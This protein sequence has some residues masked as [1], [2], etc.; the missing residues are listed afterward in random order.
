VSFRLGLILSLVFGLVTFVVLDV[1]LADFW[2]RSAEASYGVTLGIT[3]WRAYQ[4]R[5]LGPYAVLLISGLGLSYV[6]ALKV[7]T[8]IVVV[9]NAGLFYALANRVT[10]SVEKS[11]GWLIFFSL[12]RVYLQKDTYFVWD[13]LELLLFTGLGYAALFQT[14]LAPLL[15]LF[16]VGLLNRESALLIGV[17]VAMDSVRYDKGPFE[18]ALDK[19]KLA[20]GTGLTLLGIVYTK[21]S[22]DLLFIST[23]GGRQDERHA[24]IGNHLQFRWNASVILKKNWFTM[25]LLHTAIVGVAFLWLLFRFLQFSQRQQKAAILICLVFLTILLF[26]LFN[27]TRILLPLLPMFI[28]LWLS[29]RDRV[30]P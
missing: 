12:F 29:D 14:S 2:A 23:I 7:Y 30:L 8:A 5:I 6:L 21:L 13:S 18:I 19:G 22:R 27:E 20:L 28:F 3:D 4:N 24:L 15:V 9:L 16:F 25:D 17:F 11:L 26:G 10:N 1:M